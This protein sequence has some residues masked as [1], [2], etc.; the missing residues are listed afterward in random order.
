M[1]GRIRELEKQ[2][3]GSRLQVLGFRF[4]AFGSPLSATAYGYRLSAS[5]ST[6]GSQ[7][8]SDGYKF[9]VSGV[10]FRLCEVLPTYL[11]PSIS[12]LPLTSRRFLRMLALLVGG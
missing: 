3:L 12:I 10:N 4:P 1:I 7:L 2:A 9:R 6:F 11:S 8:P 5:A